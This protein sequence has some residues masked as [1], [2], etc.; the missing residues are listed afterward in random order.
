MISTN[1]FQVGSFN[2]KLHHLAVIGI[3]LL[4]FSI[5]YS[6]K[7]Q[8]LDYGHGLNEFD[9]FFN[10]RATEYLVENGLSEYFNWYDDKSWYPTGR[11]VSAT[12]QTMLHITA[13]ITYQIFGGD[14]NLYNFTILFPLIIEEHS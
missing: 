9:P 6:I 12:S 13:A 8:P 7:S 4:S 5:S 10:F 3:L 1:L 14:S 2:F 11:D